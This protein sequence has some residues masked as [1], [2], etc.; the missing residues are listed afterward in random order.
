M[1]HNAGRER[2]RTTKMRRKFLNYAAQGVI[3]HG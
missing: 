1:H 2:M 3:G